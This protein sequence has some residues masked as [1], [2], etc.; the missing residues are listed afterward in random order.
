MKQ[1]RFSHRFSL[2]IG[3][4]SLFI[5]VVTLTAPTALAL[6]GKIREFPLPTA[7]SGP[8]GITAGPDG[9]L[10]FTEA[11]S[12][13]IG[14]I[15][16]A[17]VVTEFPIPTANG[18]PAG[19]TVGPDGNLWFTNGS[20]ISGFYIGRITPSGSITVF[21]LPMPNSGL[22]SDGITAGPDG[23]LWFTESKRNNI[24]RI[25]PRASVK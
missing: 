3:L 2:F 1:R 14:R 24:G 19:I 9:N 21:P 5:C 4:L 6:S 17:G 7:N 23:N 13:N 22:G 8:Y 15:S 20:S 16:T 18:N 25:T 12:N 11:N 10:W